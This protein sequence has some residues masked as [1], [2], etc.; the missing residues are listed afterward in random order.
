MTATLKAMMDWLPVER[1]KRIKARARE[2][3]AEQ[4][5]LSDLRKARDLT[6]ARM[7]EILSIG[8]DSVSRLEQR[9]DLLLSTLSDFV[10]AMG[11][12]LEL[13]VR[14]PD[15][16]AV[17][18]KDLRDPSSKSARRNRRSRVRKDAHP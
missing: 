3:V 2:L 9:S 12:K 1:K 5:T 14:F 4:M 6:Q 13:I 11:G 8:Q 18:V 16:P 7:A 17:V 15:R 10:D